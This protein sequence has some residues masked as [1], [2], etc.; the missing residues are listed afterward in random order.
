MLESRVIEK[1]RKI[2]KNELEQNKDRNYHQNR[3]VQ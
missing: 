1:W 3:I 2:K